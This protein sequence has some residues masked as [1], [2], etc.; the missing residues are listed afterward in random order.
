MG[1]V[2]IEPTSDEK[3]TIYEEILHANE[4][5]RTAQLPTYD[6]AEEYSDQ[7]AKLR[8][9]NYRCILEPYIDSYALNH[10]VGVGFTPHL[11]WRIQAE[12][13]A[14]KQLY[15]DTG[16]VPVGA[17]RRSITGRI[18]SSMINDRSSVREE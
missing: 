10:P 18:A 4:T 8:V 9:K 15:A 5:R 3:Q 12:H 6:V 13:F 7:V 11:K 17:S 16:I 2:T 1:E 14:M